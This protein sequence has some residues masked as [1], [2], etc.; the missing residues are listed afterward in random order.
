MAVGKYSSAAPFN[1]RIGLI[2]VDNALE[3]MCHQNTT[4]ILERDR[5]SRILSPAQRNDAR[6]QIFGRK[7]AVLRAL[8]HI[9]EDQARAVTI[10]IAIVTSSTTPAFATTR[11]SAV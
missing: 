1:G 5:V 9:A 4:E 6:G 3:L 8:G 7:V 10:F 11:S 2:L